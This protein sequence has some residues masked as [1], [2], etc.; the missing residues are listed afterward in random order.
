MKIE[1]KIKSKF[2]YSN[3]LNVFKIVYF[4]YQFLKAKIIQNKR[5]LYS[6]WGLDIM[7]DHFFKNKKKGVYIDI[8]CF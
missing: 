3:G 5:K 2:L 1:E 6:N 7:A 8:G 4:Y